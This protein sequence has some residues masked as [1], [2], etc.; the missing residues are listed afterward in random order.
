M[1][2]YVYGQSMQWLKQSMRT[3]KSATT[4]GVQTWL[5]C[6]PR[7]KKGGLR[8]VLQG[9]AFEVPGDGNS[10][11]WI[12]WPTC[13]PWCGNTSLCDKQVTSSGALAAL[14]PQETCSDAILIVASTKWLVGIAVMTPTTS[15][16]LLKEKSLKAFKNGFDKHGPKG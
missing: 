13:W 16:L 11:G 14:I 6:G 10:P 5:R 9:E 2:L 8:I 4:P 15:V 1:K 7:C 12:N 3:W